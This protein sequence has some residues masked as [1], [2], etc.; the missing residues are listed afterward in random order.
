MDAGSL[1]MLLSALKVEQLTS[2]RTE[3]SGP[4]AVRFRAYEHVKFVAVLRGRFE[5]QIEGEART[6]AV[7]QGDCYMLTSGRPYRIFNANVPETDAT[8]LFSTNRDANGVVHWGD[9]AA[10]TVT[11]GSRATLNSEG[12]VLLRD[13]LIPFIRIPTGALEADRIRTILT[14]LSGEFVRGSGATLTAD[15][16]FGA[17]LEQTLR[18]VLSN[19]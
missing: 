19:G 4:F 13:K 11:V 9:G 17:L 16:Y 7:P 1:D 3:S 18:Y 12:A 15:K 6:N 2:V 10:D 5:L 8:V 14:L